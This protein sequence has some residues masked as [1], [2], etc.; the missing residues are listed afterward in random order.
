VETHDF[1][2]TLGQWSTGTGPLYHRLAT[3]IE[4]AIRAG[5][6]GPDDVL[7]PERALAAV[8]GVSR[9]TIDTAYQEVASLGF[10]ASRRGSGTR[11]TA[12]SSDARVG[13]RLFASTTYTVSQSRAQNVIDFTLGALSGV[14]SGIAPDLLQAL[15]D[16]LGADPAYGPLG[17]RDLRESIARQYTLD[18]VPTSA[19]QILVTSG[20]QQAISL[21]AALFIEPGQRV[22]VQDSTYF[23]ALDAFRAAGAKMVSLDATDLVS[24]D[25]VRLAY[26]MASVHNPTGTTMPAAQRRTLVQWARSNRVPIVDDAALADLSLDGSVHQPLIATHDDPLVITIGSLSKVAWAALRIGWIRAPRSTIERLARL[27]AVA[28]LGTTP[29]AQRLAVALL[30]RIGDLRV[31]RCAEMTTR[32]AALSRLLRREL[33]QWCWDEPTGGFALWIHILGVDQG[34]D[35]E[36]FTELALEEGVLVTP[37]SRMAVGR[38]HHDRIRVTALGDPAHFAAGVAALKRAAN[39]ISQGCASGPR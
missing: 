7:P 32:V 10:V 34:V 13:G 24:L 19:E 3:A 30:E 6:L 9:T 38:R 14:P 21:L 37:G 29:L 2:E 26:V 5:S 18:G 17:I 31:L 36:A 28:D 20:G 35:A 25:D 23:G 27:K 22:A 16:S 1:L 12:L 4:S 33:P 8:L 39:R 11:V 15:S